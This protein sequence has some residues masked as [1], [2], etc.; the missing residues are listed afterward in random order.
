MKDNYGGDGTIKYGTTICHKSAHSLK[1]INFKN[2]K[3]QLHQTALERLEKFPVILSVEQPTLQTITTLTT[4][5][6]FQ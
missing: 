2:V 5:Q 4:K 6:N 1:N 3:K